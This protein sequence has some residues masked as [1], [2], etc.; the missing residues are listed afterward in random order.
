MKG[1]LVSMYGYLE[2]SRTSTRSGKEES[3]EEAFGLLVMHILRIYRPA[4][5]SSAEIFSTRRS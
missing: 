5:L 2:T 3:K 1:L 4:G